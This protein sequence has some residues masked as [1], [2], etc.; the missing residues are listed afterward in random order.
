MKSNGIIDADFYLADIMSKDNAPILQKLQV[1][2]VNTH[3]RLDRK[4]N[5]LGLFSD[6]Y[7]EFNDEGV[8]HSRFWKRYNR[9]PKREYQDYMMSRRDLLVPQDVRER[10]G[11]YFTP[12]KW[13]D[14]AYEYLA[15]VLGDG[16]QDE[17]YVWDCCAG[18]GN[19][20][21]GLVD[22][23]KVFASTIDK[24]DVD[25]MNERIN[26]G[27]NLLPS[28]VFQFDFLNDGYG[29]DKYGTIVSQLSSCEKIPQDL[30][31]VLSDHDKRKKLVIFI[32]PPYAEASSASTTKG[33]I[34]KKAVE[35][36]ITNTLYSNTLG[37]ANA[38]L[39]A[40]FFMRI[41]KEI[42]GCVLAEFSKLKI[43][44]GPHFSD[45]RNIFLA[46]LES[47][48]VVPADTFDNVK[49]KFPIGFHIW[50][51]DIKEH[52]SEITADV[53]DKDALPIQSKIFRCHDGETYMNDWIKPFRA[54]KKG[55]SIIGIF[56]FKGKD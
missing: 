20:L 51:T 23:Y 10:K 19:L 16:W 49:G 14:L 33:G 38:E 43:L 5:H 13:V 55:S 15:K 12:Q 36:T 2:L 11:S 42:P 17:Y 45:F 31:D 28:H 8:A 3:Y 18:T 40:Q 35:K 34:S 37:Q 7:A 39:F 6:S 50:K 30:R 22:K 26:S 24:S 29:C 46:R 48:F 1:L 21:T 53:Y 4:K 41:Y 9:P 32:N 54:D 25:V 56:P 27:A 47:L 52:F 44:T